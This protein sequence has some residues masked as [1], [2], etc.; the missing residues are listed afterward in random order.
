MQYRERIQEQ[1][2]FTTWAI[3]LIATIGSLF[4]SEFMGFLPCDLCWYQRIF[5][6][7]LVIHIGIAVVR[8]DFRQSFYAFI[9]ATIGGTIS[10]YHYLKQKVPYLKG[11]ISDSCGRIPCTTDYINWF[12]FITIPFLALTAFSLIAVINFLIWKDVKGQEQS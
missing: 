10:I 12:G 8:K 6:Y 1:A 7:P 3:S 4:F 11:E 9:L 5:M 2:L